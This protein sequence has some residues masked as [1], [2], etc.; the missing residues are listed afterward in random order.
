MSYLNFKT[1]ALALGLAA[2]GGFAAYTS[3]GPK[4]DVIYENVEAAPARIAWYATLDSALA[5]AKRSQRPILFTS[6]APA[7]TGVPGVW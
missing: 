7:C 5:E 3:G 4:P 2:V 1:I 6:A